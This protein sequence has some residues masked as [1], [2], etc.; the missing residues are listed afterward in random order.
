MKCYD[1]R[2]LNGT[3]AQLTAERDEL[4]RVNAR[5]REALESVQTVVGDALICTTGYGA[6][7]DVSRCPHCEEFRGHGHECPGESDK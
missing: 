4:K 7:F 5:L 3:I 1:C 6:R 2:V